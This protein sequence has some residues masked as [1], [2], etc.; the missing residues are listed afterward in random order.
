MVEE[1]IVRSYVHETQYGFLVTDQGDLYFDLRG[2]HKWNGSTWEE[3]TGSMRN[4]V[5]DRN[6]IEVGIKVYFE[7][8]STDKGWRAQPWGFVDNLIP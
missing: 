8:T 7:R 6:L 3:I 2:L 5:R 4:K 1:A